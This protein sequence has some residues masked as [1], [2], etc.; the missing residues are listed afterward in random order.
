MRR[1]VNR[2]EMEAVQLRESVRMRDEFLSTASHE[3]RT[4][5][6]PLQLELD[7][8]ARSLVESGA[9]E[10]L[11]SRVDRARRQTQRLIRLVENLLDVSQITTG[12]ILLEFEDSDLSE[13]GRTGVDQVMSE[14][15]VAGCDVTVNALAPV[16]GTWDR[17]RIEQVLANLLSNAIKYGAGKPIEVALTESDGLARLS[18]TDHGIGVAPENA[19]R[20]FRRF[21]RAASIRHY[22]G[23]GL[24]LYIARQI[25]EAHGG[26]LIVASQLGAGAMFTMLLPLQTSL[27]TLRASPWKH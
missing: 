11:R 27:S 25:V 17:S 4:P 24:G 14:A 26:S 15:A 3:L 20:I 10:K 13:I 1:K 8:V 16:M 22:S 23:L 12:Q 18:V 2:R 7:I 9:D 21:E 19:D 5:L 6:T